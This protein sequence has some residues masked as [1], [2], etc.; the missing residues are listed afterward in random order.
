MRPSS[1]GSP[2]PATFP[3]RGHMQVGN[4]E[5]MGASGVQVSWWDQGS[6]FNHVPDK[7]PLY[8]RVHSTCLP[9]WTHLGPEQVVRINTKE[10]FCDNTWG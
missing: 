8:Q 1:W 7:N 10:G 4:Q 2:S 9:Q 5:V 6:T 3:G